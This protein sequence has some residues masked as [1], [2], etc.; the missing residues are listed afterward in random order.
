[1]Y[2]T[3]YRIR[4]KPG[5]EAEV[6]ALVDEWNRERRPKVKGA[7]AGYLFKLD[8]GGMMGVGIFESKETYTANAGD[9][10]QDR[11]YRRLRDLLE[12]DPE[13]NDGE[14]VAGGSR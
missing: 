3:I 12:A 2:G 4:P 1:M 14:I 10:E 6:A 13:W 7:V 9:P 8:K 11:W 5:K